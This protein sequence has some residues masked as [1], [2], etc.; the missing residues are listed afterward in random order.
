MPARQAV[1][2]SGAQL[3]G[4]SVTEMFPADSLAPEDSARDV[5][6]GRLAAGRTWG[7]CEPLEP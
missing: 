7:V 5:R 4:M 1:L 2:V 6:V 3:P